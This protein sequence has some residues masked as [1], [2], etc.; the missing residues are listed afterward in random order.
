VFP[1]HFAQQ[2]QPGSGDLSVDDA[3]IVPGARALDEAAAFQAI[4]QARNVG[5]V[6]D[7]ALADFAARQALCPSPAQDAQRV[8]LRAGE[9]ELFELGFDLRLERVGG[10]QQR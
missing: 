5:I 3:A 8:V 1:I 2:L 10:A 9:S 6:R 4:E 7:H